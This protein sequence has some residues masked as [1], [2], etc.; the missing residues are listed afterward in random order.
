MQVVGAV[1]GATLG[2]IVGNV[3]GAVAGAK[4]GWEAGNSYQ[5]TM[6]PSITGSSRKRRGSAS[7]TIRGSASRRRVSVSGGS[8]V[9]NRRP[10]TVSSGSRRSSLLSRASTGGMSY[11]RGGRIGKSKYKKASRKMK[12]YKK[13]KRNKFVSKNK[14][15]ATGFHRTY[16]QFGTVS[17]GDTVYL[18]HSSMFV[19]EISNTLYAA[20]LRKI[21]NK[22]G[23]KMSGLFR[24]IAVSDPGVVAGT[25]ENSFGLR[26]IYTIKTQM[27]GTEQNFFFYTSDGQNFGDVL[28]GFAQMRNHLNQ[29]L[30]DRLDLVIADALP[31]TREPYKLAVYKADND[32]T[33]IRW[34]LGAEMFLEDLS[35]NISVKSELTVQNRTAAATGTGVFD[36]DRID[37]QPL[38]G[39]LYDFKH[40]DPRVRFGGFT[41][42][43]I[44]NQVFNQMPSTGL[45][46][47]RGSQFSSA[48][49]PL[50]GKY[51]ANIQK[52][53][54]FTL[55]PGEMK[56]CFLTYQYKGKLVNLLKK[57]Q[58]TNF[59]AATNSFNGVIGKSQMLGFEE[60]LRTP[61]EN[62]VTIAYQRAFNA[63]CTCYYKPSTTPL[64]NVLNTLQINNLG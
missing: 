18:A 7:S 12:A 51:F 1:S 17:S 14:A 36:T 11:K 27:V 55:S 3:P 42:S 31:E 47:I 64:D 40:A 37:T 4:F 23:F 59:E 53:Q 22:A 26:F 33:T 34:R 60:A 61:S 6:Q 50:T 46:L 52:T 56:K 43:T 29:F 8:Y 20:M 45:N 32:G 2:Y 15:Q 39:Y 21:L 54:K 57:M 28:N 10:S 30:M 41:S 25:S 58:A 62:L 49:E 38:I 13:A 16:E 24:E 5:N 44:S 63:G 9:S 48:Q 35:V 19:D